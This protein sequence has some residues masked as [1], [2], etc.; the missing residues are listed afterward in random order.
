MTQGLALTVVGNLTGDP[1][2]RFTQS[3][4]AVATFTV[5]STPR[6]RDKT[7]EF[8]D[9]PTSFVRCTAWR[10]LAE[11]VAESLRRGARVVVVGEL[12][13][14]E[15]ET[16]EGDKRRTWELTAEE[17]GPSLLYANATVRK[18]GRGSAGT[19]PPDDEF[20][21]PKAGPTAVPNVA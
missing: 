12:R 4:T 8:Q 13:Q 16:A 3:G 2:M 21:Q 6:Y 11:H 10:S 14:R 15:F 19:A 9:G 5:A 17:V 18:V 7:G 20:T 1:E